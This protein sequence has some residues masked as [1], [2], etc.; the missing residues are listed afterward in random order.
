M[1]V[2]NAPW[3]RQFWL[4]FIL[5]PLFIV[6]TA[7]IGML[8]LAIRTH[9]G[10]IIDNP[11]KDGKGFVERTAEDAFAREHNLVAI[12]TRSGNNVRIELRGDLAPMPEQL[13]LL[14]AFPTAQALDTTI[15]LNHQGLGRYI[16]EL[17]E[18]NLGRRQLLLEPLGTEQGWRLH[19]DGLIADDQLELTLLPKAE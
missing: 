10:V 1:T 13:E 11:Y 9:D 5:T 19:F 12:F 17:D 3:Y 18:Q 6:I 2:D 15:Q 16:G 7:C 8:V 4:W 14:L